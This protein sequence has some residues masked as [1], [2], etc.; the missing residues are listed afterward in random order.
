MFDWSHKSYGWTDSFFPSSKKPELE[1]ES[2]LEFYRILA[3]IS[4]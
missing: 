1:W 2:K 3:D 4:E